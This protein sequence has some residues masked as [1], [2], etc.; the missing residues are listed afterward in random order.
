MN[1]NEID[2]RLIAMLDA[3]A[4]GAKPSRA[5]RAGGMNLEGFNTL[6]RVS[7]HDDR[8]VVIWKNE[9]RSLSDHVLH[10]RNLGRVANLNALRGITIDGEVQYVMDPAL[11]AKFGFPDDPDAATMAELHGYTDYPYVHDIEGSRIPLL[12]A[13]HPRPQRQHRPHPHTGRHGTFEKAPTPAPQPVT[14]GPPPYARRTKPPAP[15]TPK[16]KLPLS[17]MMEAAV[18]RL[19]ASAAIPPRNP[20]PTDRDGRPMRA[21]T[22]TVPNTSDPPE[23]ISRGAHH[24]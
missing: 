7:E 21:N 22:G 12:S 3:L 1:D 24:E 15:A 23:Q 8:Y 11:L 14:Q 6:C 16:S 20:R 19:R 17:P 9:R 5:A 10:A 4:S 13:R 2:Q 18:A